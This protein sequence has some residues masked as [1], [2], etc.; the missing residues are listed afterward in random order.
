LF[1]S[2]DH[3]A[4]NPDTQTTMASSGTSS[5]AVIVLDLYVRQ[6]SAFRVEEWHAA[7][8]EKGWS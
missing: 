5:R 2:R 1:Y 7:M 8:P 4:Q 6:D 3:G